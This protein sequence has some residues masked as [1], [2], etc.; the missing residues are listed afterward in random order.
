MQ[1][2]HD[3]RLVQSWGRVSLRNGVNFQP[4]MIHDE[5]FDTCPLP[6]VPDYWPRLWSAYCAWEKGVL[7]DPGGYRDQPAWFTALMP[8]IGSC[9]DRA[10]TDRRKRERHG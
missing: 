5:R 2:G 8:V 9:L 7:P 1:P 4:W 6:M 10:R 3:G